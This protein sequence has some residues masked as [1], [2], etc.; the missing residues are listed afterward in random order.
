[1]RQTLV[2]L[3]M[4]NR[5]DR[6]AFVSGGGGGIG[7]E[8]A[9]QFAA[10]GARVVV[11]DLDSGAAERVAEGIRTSGGE[12]VSVALD[13]TDM[14]SVQ[15]A[16]SAATEAF[17]P[18]EILANVVGWD[19]MVP[20]IDTD[21]EFWAKV[22][23]INYTGMLRT[24]STALPSMIE[25]GWGR[26][27]NVASDAGRV[28]SSLESVYSGAKGGVIAFS[29]TLARE[30]AKKGITVNTV[31]PGPTDTNLLADAGG[32][33]PGGG[34][35]FLGSL[36]RAIPMGRIAEA[37]DVA[38]AIVFFASEQAGYITGQTLSVSGG[39]TMA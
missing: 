5:L 22:I 37:S 24:C 17:G 23:E 13:V 27:V 32:S 11:A 2:S 30:M 6:V 36:G 12:A 25:H 28:G 7:G 8:S 38:P 1:M 18:V 35:K 16:L 29:K 19:R 31:C 20:F 14:A 34:E 10:K 39:L 26:I 21:E 15:A 33:I 3:T 4:G 9:R